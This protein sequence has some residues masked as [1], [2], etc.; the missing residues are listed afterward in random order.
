M[1]VTTRRERREREHAGLTQP[2]D[3]DDEEDDGAEP[4]EPAPSAAT[5][6]ARRVAAALFALTLAELA[7][8]PLAARGDTHRF[9]STVSRLE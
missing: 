8:A 1:S 7:F 2:E 9:E 5:A 3:H 6:T 4:D